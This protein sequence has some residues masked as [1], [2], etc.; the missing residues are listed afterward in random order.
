MMDINVE[1]L[2][3]FINFLIKR[4][5]V[6]LFHGQINLPLKVKSRKNISRRITQTNYRKI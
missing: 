1:W 3:W 6:V 5:L 2:Q 4:P